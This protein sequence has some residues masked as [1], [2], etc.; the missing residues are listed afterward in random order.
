MHSLQTSPPPA[1]PPEKKKK[2]DIADEMRIT[3]TYI[4]NFLLTLTTT[5][6]GAKEK[7][8]TPDEIKFMYKKNFVAAIQSIYTRNQFMHWQTE[9]KQ[10]TGACSFPAFARSSPTC[11]PRE[12]SAQLRQSKKETMT[13]TVMW[14]MPLLLASPT[15]NWPL[16]VSTK[17]VS[18]SENTVSKLVFY[19]QSTGAVISG[20]LKI[21]YNLF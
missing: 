8:G 3:Y 21:L 15:Y 18:N 16:T 5:K 7:Q 20:W 13:Q 10:H 19:A 11:K 14:V 17:V 2:T 4:K 6:K 1:P 9:S 12:T